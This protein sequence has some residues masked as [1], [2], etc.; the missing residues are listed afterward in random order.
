MPFD[1]EARPPSPPAR[2][3]SDMTSFVS[4]RASRCRRRPTPQCAGSVPQRTAPAS[5]RALGAASA[6][7]LA[8]AP[9][10]REARVPRKGRP[11][12]AA[13]RCSSERKGGLRGSGRSPSLR[14]RLGGPA[15]VHRPSAGEEISGMV[16]A[17]ARAVRAAGAG[18]DRRP[19]DLPTSHKP[20]FRRKAP[21]SSRS[22]RR[23]CL[24][25]RA[26][27][28]SSPGSLLVAIRD[29]GGAS[30]RALL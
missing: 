15:A 13:T 29:G 16:D 12:P 27:A 7:R 20:R 24:H 11:S 3:N 5:R 18:R 2:A 25:A 19:R 23:P 26:G 8:A 1:A 30:R 22:A 21:A 28:L 6:P 14:H 9:E 4:G 17:P 10:P